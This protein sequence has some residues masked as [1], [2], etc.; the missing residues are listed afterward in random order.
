MGE[1]SDATR[2]PAACEFAP[3]LENIRSALKGCHPPLEV[4]RLAGTGRVRVEAAVASD[5]A[6]WH[7]LELDKRRNLI[8]ESDDGV[9]NEQRLCP[10]ILE[11]TWSRRARLAKRG[12]TRSHRWMANPPRPLMGAGIDP[13]S[14]AVLQSARSLV[15]LGGGQRVL[16][17]V[18]FRDGFVSLHDKQLGDISARLGLLSPHILINRDSWT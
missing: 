18:R 6:R 7:D 11:P 14:G 9:P 8:S 1:T 13:P 12:I 3:Q 10:S 4:S 2:R 16:V 17:S 5:G 15:L